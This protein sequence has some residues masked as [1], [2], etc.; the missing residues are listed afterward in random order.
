MRDTNTYNER[1]GKVLDLIEHC[2]KE[3]SEKDWTG[4]NITSIF[5]FE[6]FELDFKK[7]CVDLIELANQYPEHIRIER[8]FDLANTEHWMMY[9]YIDIHGNKQAPHY[10]EEQVILP[11]AELHILSPRGAL[12]VAMKKA[13]RNWKDKRVLLTIDFQEGIFPTETP[14]LHYTLRKKTSERKSLIALLL[15]ARQ[16]LTASQIGAVLSTQSKKIRSWIGDVN[17]IF[18]NSTS[19]VEPLIL[20]RSDQGYYLNR[21][22]YKITSK[23]VPK[24]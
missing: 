20:N 16:P 2:Q 8:I 17:K 19:C 1:I 11:I 22:V 6:D 5:D 23:H 15:K 10:P 21:D 24:N 18:M 3:H 14:E 9:D 7:T 4:K 13:T 12:R